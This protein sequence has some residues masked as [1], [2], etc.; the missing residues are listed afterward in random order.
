MKIHVIVLFLMMPFLAYSGETLSLYEA[1]QLAVS[2]NRKI[3]QAE[4]ERQASG[5]QTRSAFNN[6][7]PRFDFEGGYQLRGKK[8]SLLENDMFLPVIPYEGIDGSSGTFNSALA[9]GAFAMHPETGQPILNADGTPVFQNYAWLPQSEVEVGSKHNWQFGVSMRQPLYMGGKI[10]RGHE[11]AQRAESISEAREELTIMEVIARTDELYWQVV[12]LC[13]MLSL[14]NSYIEM[15]ENLEQDMENLFREGIVTR[16]QLLQ[17]QVRKNEVKLSAIQV[18]N[19]L[20]LSR[21][22]LNQFVGLPFYDRAELSETFSPEMLKME[23]GLY[24]DLALEQRQELRMMNEA[25]TIAEKL[26]QVERAEMMPAIGIMAG[27]SVSNPNPYNGFAR[28]FGGDYS[29]GVGISIPIFHFGEKRNQVAQAKIA[30]QQQQLELEETREMVQL[31][32][33][34]E[35]LSFHESKSRLDLANLSLEQAEENLRVTNNLFNEGRAT[36]R[37]VLEAQAHWQD[38]HATSISAKA[39]HRLAYTNL[40]K[41]IGDL[42]ISDNQ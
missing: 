34:R 15:L 31:Q 27:Y 13:E 36:T 5:L 11:I 18:E 37:D 38:A 30:R 20:E 4:L 9:P 26:V 21:L 32:V 22:A 29:V 10:R 40:Q 1:R 23:E 41:A 39:A 16:N 2:H 35:L 3:K 25:V 12:Q 19:G 14:T 6:F 33:S 24:T 8:Y 7:L 42:K 28:E 17:V